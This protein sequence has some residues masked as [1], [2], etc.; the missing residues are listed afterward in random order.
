MRTEHEFARWATPQESAG[1]PAMGT[2]KVAWVVDP[3]WR[4]LDAGEEDHRCR[5][6][7]ECSSRVVAALSRRYGRNQQRHWWFYC[8]EHLYGRL[9]EQGRVLMPVL[10]DAAEA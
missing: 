1:M 8:S 3:D 4:L 10:M 9:I 5:G 7:R 6:G 2:K